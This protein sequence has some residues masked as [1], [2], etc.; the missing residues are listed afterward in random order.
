MN[1]K[2]ADCVSEFGEFDNYCSRCGKSLDGEMSPETEKLF[3]L[4]VDL[5]WDLNV[6]G[7]LERLNDALAIRI[8]DALKIPMEL[9]WFDSQ[10][11]RDVWEGYH[12]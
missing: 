1:P 3:R 6:N 5:A 7:G 11:L 4:L 12:S 8:C 10:A 2:C 9:Y